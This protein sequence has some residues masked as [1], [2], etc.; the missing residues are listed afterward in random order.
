MTKIIYIN[1]FRGGGPSAKIDALHEA[2][3]DSVYN[4][5]VPARFDKAVVAIANMVE[6]C[7]YE[8]YVFVG[9]SLGGFYAAWA[10]RKYRAKALLLNPSLFPAHTL[11][12]YIGELVDGTLWDEFDC[13][14]FADKIDMNSGDPMIVLCER[15]DTVI[16]WHET[17]VLLNMDKPYHADMRVLQGG[18]HRFENYE[19]MIEAVEELMFQ[20][21][22]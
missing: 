22:C 13:R 14:A 9:T 5:Y 3:P 17:Y 16:D 12:K 10:A 20:D 18:S 11:R 21:P 19:K 15:G 8:D 2:F 1:G 6:K 4:D 7:G